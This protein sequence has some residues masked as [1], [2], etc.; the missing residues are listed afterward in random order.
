VAVSGE[1][2]RFAWEAGGAG[3][4]KCPFCGEEHEPGPVGE[5]GTLFAGIEI[6]TCPKLPAESMYEDRE[7]ESGPRGALH[8]VKPA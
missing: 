1:G 8:Y 7:Y 3:V 6:K 2:L 5:P 4:S